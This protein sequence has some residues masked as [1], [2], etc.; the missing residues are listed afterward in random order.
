MRSRASKDYRGE[1]SLGEFCSCRQA[2]GARTYD[3]DIG[4]ILLSEFIASTRHFSFRVAQRGLT[5]HVPWN[6]LSRFC[7]S[8]HFSHMFKIVDESLH[9][10]VASVFVR[11]SKDG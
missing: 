2:G 6:V 5:T 8:G 11:R 9:P 1:T 7:L 3:Y 10:Q 4:T